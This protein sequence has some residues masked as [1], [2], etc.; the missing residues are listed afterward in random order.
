MST[1]LVVLDMAGTTVTDD[2][3]VAI[4]FQNA[5]LQNGVMISVEEVKPLMGYTKRVAIEKVLE[6]NHVK[7]D[8]QLV[9]NIHNDFIDDM[10][11]HYHLSPDVRPAP[12][13]EELLTW[14][15]EKGIRVALNTG[16]P[17]EIADVIVGRF[18]WMEKNLVDE[19]IA[20]DEVE[21]G[22]P[23]P[24]M[25]EQLMRSGGI[26]DSKEVVKVGDTEVDINEGRNAGCGIVVA[27]TSGA[28]TRDQLRRYQ[29]DHIIDTLKELED[30]IGR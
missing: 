3:A 19:Y 25:I 18:Q 27:V 20:S 21:Q 9:E 17:K 14:L 15:K 2:D 8:T 10:I 28:F 13:A 5:F 22:R 11:Q 6:M 30:I 7:Y 16:F 4:S 26:T 23:F 29:P 1:R 12:Y 24:F